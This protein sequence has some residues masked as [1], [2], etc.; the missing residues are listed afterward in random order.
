[1]QNERFAELSL[2]LVDETRRVWRRSEVRL[3]DAG[4]LHVCTNRRVELIGDVAG[5]AIDDGEMDAFASEALD[6]RGADASR[7]RNDRAAPF[8]LEHVAV[9]LIR[10]RYRRSSRMSTY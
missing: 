5:T 2:R 4:A 10:P 9:R 1:M 3:D 8:Q 6:D 7:S